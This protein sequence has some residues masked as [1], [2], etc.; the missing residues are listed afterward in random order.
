[1]WDY[2]LG[3]R[4]IQNQARQ[5]AGDQDGKTLTATGMETPLAI[6]PPPHCAD[7]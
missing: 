7:P 5:G 6:A 2:Q 1:M 3:I 4:F